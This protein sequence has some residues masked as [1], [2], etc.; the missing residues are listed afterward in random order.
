MRIKYHKNLK[1]H[2]IGYNKIKHL[3][4]FL[5]SIEGLQCKKIFSLFLFIKIYFTILSNFYF[6]GRSYRENLG[7]PVFY[8]KVN[9]PRLYFIVN[10]CGAILV[11]D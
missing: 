2:Y 7:C 1:Q 3:F 10:T 6:P 8:L 4:F 11:S 5:I 9:C